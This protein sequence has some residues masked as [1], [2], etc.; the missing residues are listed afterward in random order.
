MTSEQPTRTFASIGIDID[1]DKDVFHVVGFDTSGKVVLRKKFKRLK[2]LINGTLPDE[3][4]AT[5]VAGD[6]LVGA[7]PCL[8]TNLPNWNAR[9]R[10]AGSKSCTE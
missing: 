7:M 1:I 10:C 3:H 5:D 8:L 4:T 2:K 9:H 6:G